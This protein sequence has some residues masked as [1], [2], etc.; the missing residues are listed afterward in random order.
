MICRVIE[1]IFIT[2]NHDSSESVV[3]QTVVSFCGHLFNYIR[4]ESH[5]NLLILNL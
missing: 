1:C 4:N 2:I 5:S 3:T